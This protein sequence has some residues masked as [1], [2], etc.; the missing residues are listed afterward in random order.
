MKTIDK[1]K[2][3]DL[4][5][6]DTFEFMLFTEYSKNFSKEYSLQLIINRVEGDYSQLSESLQ[7]IAENY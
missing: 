3:F 6:L 4:N 2:N 5:L 1:L 7:K